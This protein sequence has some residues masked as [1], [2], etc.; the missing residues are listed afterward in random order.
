MLKNNVVRSLENLS[1]QANSSL[2]EVLSL[3]LKVSLLILEEPPFLLETLLL[4]Q[5]VAVVQKSCRL[6]IERRVELLLDR[7]KTSVLIICDQIIL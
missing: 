1:S 7:Q 5:R 4:L 6:V 3:P 2:R